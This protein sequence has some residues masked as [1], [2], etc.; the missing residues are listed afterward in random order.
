MPNESILPN[1]WYY[2]NAIRKNLPIKA[3]NETQNCEVL[4]IGGGLSGMGAALRLAKSN[5]D[6]ILLE[7][8]NIGSGASGRNGG[9][10]CSGY[11]HDQKWLE[12]K[13]GKIA[14]LDLWN[15]SQ[16][17]K[18]HL[19]SLV[20]NHSINADYEKGLFFAAH[21]E[22]M[23][24]YLINDSAHLSNIY[25]YN[26][27]EIQNKNQAQATLGTDVYYGGVLDKNA[28]RIHP[29]KLLYG[30]MDAAIKYGAK[31]YENSKAI[32][33]EEINEKVKIAH[34]NGVIFAKKLII[35]GDGYLHGIN[36][37]I[38]AKVLPIYS[39]VI[40]TEPLEKDFLKGAIGAMD[41]KFVVNYFQKTS[42][43][44]LLFGGGEKYSA[45]W[46]NDVAKFVRKNLLKIYPD[47]KNVKIEYSWGGALGITSTRLPFVR[48][49]SKNIITSAGYSGQGVLLAPF[50]GDILG[51]LIIN[52]NIDFEKINK[53][54]VPDFP[55][56][57]MLR[58]PLLSAA[59]SYYS[60]LDR[61]P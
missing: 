23:M 55:G 49:I 41:T 40:A 42:D 4:I 61:L 34:S 43:N 27:L 11:R 54:P 1:S 48:Q 22:K 36:K 19:E 44:R 29:L 31:I 12:K 7:A 30:M 10:I 45:N 39:F 17:A 37:T 16:S 13:M 5:I 3:P 59:M 51:R 25:N 21:N 56:G 15:I 50:F 26:D 58:F 46:P 14:A 47:F 18:S 57:R 33:I 28:G 8:F 2:K 60:I 9:L 52:D 35:C 20:G 38:E 53:M 24:D 32:K 6:V